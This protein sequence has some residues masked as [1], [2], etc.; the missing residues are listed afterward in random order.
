[1]R[2]SSTLIGSEVTGPI[3]ASVCRRHLFRAG[4]LPGIVVLLGCAD[5]VATRPLAHGGSEAPGSSVAGALPAA[6]IV[7]LRRDAV[8]VP[9]VASRL[10]SRHSGSLGYV[11]TAALKGF[12][13][14]LTEAA[15]RALL[16]DPLVAYVEPD[17]VVEADVTQSN[18]TWGLDRID[19][20][21]LPL[22]GTYSYSEGGWGVNVYIIDTGIRTTHAEF[23]GRATGAFTAVNDGN[24]TNDCDGH[25]T[26]VA[27]TVGG[28]ISGVAKKVR[29]Y[30]VRVL[31]CDGRGTLS[32]VIAGV[33]WVTANH[34]S[35]AVAN[36][37]LGAGISPA[38]DD[39]VTAS[40]AAGVVYAVSAGN[41]NSLG[42]AQDACTQSPARVPG[43]LTVSA[44]TSSD[45]KASWANYGTCVDIFAPGVG[46]TS[47]YNRND[48]DA[49]VLNGTSMASPHVAGAAALYLG[50]NQGASPA[51]VTTALLENSVTGKVI[52]PGL[53][54]PN[55]LLNT[56]FVTTAEPPLPVIPPPT[57]PRSP[58]NLT[59]RA[60]GGTEIVLSWS[61]ESDNE[62]A[63]AVERCT[64]A[65]CTA[66]KEIATVAENTTTFT[67][68]LLQT[69]TAY[70]YRVRAR[71]R[72]G[73]SPYSNSATAVTEFALP[74][75]LRDEPPVARFTWSCVGQSC[76]FDG[77]SSTDDRGVVNYR[78]AL[79]D[80]E[81]AKVSNFTH[82]YRDLGTFNVALTVGDGKQISTRSCAITSGTSGSC[83]P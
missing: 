69:G 61:D 51:D 55:R 75:G 14:H 32:G 16:A 33:D 30:A 59:A 44:S 62:D 56:M 2:Q 1:M 54:S 53:A 66:F 3:L 81:T 15:K 82:V 24:G 28:G 63:F 34:A 23:G 73:D 50:R 22:T 27:G 74:S 60:N 31:G 12:S 38:L 80:G 67:S 48:A 39:A 52:D 4:A 79:G 21:D 7:V 25:G 72:V 29:L 5:A 41:G 58:S 47:S 37:S 35:P 42:V 26:H 68:A 64:G 10:V 83:A 9:G 17:Q 11:Y 13:A 18:A 49:A 36:M 19:Q 70:T 20:R 6:Y 65:G 78:W 43:A 46:I 76:T 71:N 45:A 57:A 77:L 40:I 8:D